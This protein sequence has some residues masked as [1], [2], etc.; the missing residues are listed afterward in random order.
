MKTP[1]SYKMYSKYSFIV[2]YKLV[3]LIYRALIKEPETANGK[4]YFPLTARQNTV[5]TA[6]SSVSSGEGLGRDLS[7]TA[8]EM[9]PLVP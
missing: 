3:H 7:L 9:Y 1:G 5:C 4:R 6:K 8:L 2:F